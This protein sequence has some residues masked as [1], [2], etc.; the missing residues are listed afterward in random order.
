MIAA[1][2]RVAGFRIALVA[3][4]LLGA[5]ALALATT[6]KNRLV[7]NCTQSQSAPKTIV[8]ACADANALVIHIHW[9]KFGGAKAS[10]SGTYSVN[11][12]TPDCVAG[13]F[14]NYKVTLVASQ[15][16]PCGEVNDYRALA[17]TFVATAPPATR[18]PLKY[19]LYCPIG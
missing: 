2:R 19:A 9:S 16:K 6:A 7:G 15:A 17:L 11:G 13:K 1:M 8:L 18:S 10:G 3:L 5:P 14:K 4:S 12:C